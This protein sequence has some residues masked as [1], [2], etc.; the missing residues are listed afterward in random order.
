MLGRDTVVNK[1]YYVYNIHHRFNVKR[2]SLWTS[3]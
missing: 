2:N 3:V 1:H